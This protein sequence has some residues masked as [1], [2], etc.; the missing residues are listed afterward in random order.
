MDSVGEREML[1]CMACKK[2]LTR[3]FGNLK[4]AMDADDGQP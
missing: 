2:K 4:A 1:I 3:Q